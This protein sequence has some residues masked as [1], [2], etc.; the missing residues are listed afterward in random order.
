MNKIW[1]SKNQ[2]IS[3]VDNLIK[4]LVDGIAKEKEDPVDISN[5]DFVFC[6]IEHKIRNQYLLQNRAVYRVLPKGE[7]VLDITFTDLGGGIY[8]AATTGWYA[9]GELFR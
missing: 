9:P 2:S 7:Q 8:M 4:V 1:V 3:N 6:Y 5:R